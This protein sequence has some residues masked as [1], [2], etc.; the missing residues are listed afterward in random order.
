[1]E[2]FRNWLKMMSK[3]LLDDNSHFTVV[4]FFLLLFLSLKILY[5]IDILEIIEGLIKN[6][7]WIEKRCITLLKIKMR[8]QPQLQQQALQPLQ[9][10]LQPLQQQLQSLQQ[11]LQPLQQQLQPLQ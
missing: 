6:N 9:L 8:P 1:M 10:Q 7:N 3:M 4:S 2:W 5:Q 11:Q